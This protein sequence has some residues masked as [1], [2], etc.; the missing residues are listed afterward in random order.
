MNATAI[1]GVLALALAGGLGWALFAL[2]RANAALAVAEHRLQASGAD[3]PAHAAQAAQL[4]ADELIKRAAE[5]FRPVSETLAKFQEQVAAVEQARVKDAGGLN[6][7]LAALMRASAATQTEAHKLSVA[8]RGGAGVQGRWAEQTLRN[9]LQSAGLTRFDFTEQQT[10]TSEQGRFRPDVTVR[11]P[12]GGVFVIDSKCPLTAFREAEDA[13]DEAERQ[14]ALVRHAHSVRSH[15]SS[16]SGRAYWD[17]FPKGQSPDFVAM[18]VPADGMLAAALDKLPDLMTEAL[19]RRVLI[20]TP[21]TLFAAC[22]AVA[23]GWRVEEQ[24]VNAAKIAELA[25]ELY[26]RLSVMGG[27]VQGMGRGLEQAIKT[28]NAFVGSL[29][30]QVLTQARRF[31]ELAADHE[32]KPMPVL[33]PIETGLRPLAKLDASEPAAERVQALTLRAR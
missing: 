13:S 24:A 25:R 26:K 31:E 15:M 5:T 1:L 22:K 7:Q 11:F 27:H 16:L 30:T 4:A 33:E 32:T 19:E 23:Y 14:A 10:I 18:F 6:E 29:E 3:V 2:A 28:Y 17:Q 8:L 9:V 20:V 21:M 12:G